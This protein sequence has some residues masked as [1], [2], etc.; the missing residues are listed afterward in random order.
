MKMLLLSLLLALPLPAFASWVVELENID[1]KVAAREISTI[2]KKNFIVADDLNQKIT[3]NIRTPVSDEDLYH[4][5]ISAL[6]MH[7]IR[8]IEM[9]GFIQV[10]ADVGG[11]D[12]IKLNY[13][14]AQDVANIVNHLAFDGI[15][16]VADVASNSIIV[17]SK[18]SNNIRDLVSKLDNKR[19]QVLIRAVI[20]EVSADDVN[21]LGIQWVLGQENGYG[22]L[23]LN[24]KVALS[25][26]ISDTVS[27]NPALSVLGGI[28]S[29]G[30]NQDNKFYGAVLQALNQT[31]NANLLSMPS[32]L[33]LDNEQANILV[34]QNVPFLTGSYSKDDGREFQIIERQDVGIN[35]RVKPQIADDN[36]KLKI[37]QEVSSVVNTQ[38][39]SGIIT[40]KNVIDTTVLTKDGQTIVLGGLMRDDSL[41]DSQSLPGLSKI[42]VLGR[43][44]KSNQDVRKKSNLLIFL[45]PTILNDDNKSQPIIVDPTTNEVIKLIVDHG[46]VQRI[47]LDQ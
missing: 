35:L 20:V 11:S 16:A 46:Q 9:G 2:T 29:Y 5:F 23:N 1:V 15:S 26:V 41:V 31:T 18:S 13:A 12:V 40:N 47:V 43:A 17:K 28:L 30:K 14:N 27:K 7:N 22:V 34:G 10:V 32:V 44:F 6:K 39:S 8:A 45:Q 4:Y 42:P 21:Q 25:S 24:P 33:A 37:Y 3:I 19:Q 36:I 38:N